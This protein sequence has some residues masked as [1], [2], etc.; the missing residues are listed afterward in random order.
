MQSASGLIRIAMIRGG[1]WRLVA[2][3]AHAVR[4]VRE[5]SNWYA[6]LVF[7]LVRRAP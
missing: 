1:T 3:A 2:E 6:S 4:A 7:S 5:T